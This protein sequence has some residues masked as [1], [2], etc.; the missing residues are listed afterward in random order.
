MEQLISQSDERHDD[1][2]DERHDER[3]D[4][5]LLLYVY[6]IY[7]YEHIVIKKMLKNKDYEWLDEYIMYSYFLYGTTLRHK[8]S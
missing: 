3:R 1:R 6:H 8:H 4:S 2:Y 5:Y 7:I